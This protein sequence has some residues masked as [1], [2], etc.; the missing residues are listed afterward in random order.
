MILIGFQAFCQLD[1]RMGK[2]YKSPKRT[3]FEGYIGVDSTGAY[4]LDYEYVSK[5]KHM[6]YLNKFDKKTMN[7][8]YTKDISP[9]TEGDDYVEPVEIFNLSNK[10]YLSA[11]YIKPDKDLKRIAI[12][13]ITADGVLEKPILLDTVFSL[14]EKVNDFRI[15]VS[16][17]ENNIVLITRRPFFRNENTSF[18]V[19]KYDSNFKLI[20]EGVIT[21]PYEAKH[22]EFKDLA[23]DG[24]SKIMVLAKPMDITGMISNQLKKIENNKYHLWVYNHE[25]TS[26]KEFEISLKEK[27][28]TEIKIMYRNHRIFVSGYFSNK[29]GIALK[30]FFSIRF[31]EELN[32]LGATVK[33][34]SQ[35][36]LKKF[37][38]PDEVDERTHLLDFFLREAFV[39]ENGEIVMIGEKYYKEIDQYYDPRTDISSYTDLY[40]YN[41][42]LVT[43]ISA[44]G[45]KITNIK[46]PKY[47]QTIN[48]NGYFSSISYGIDKNVVWVFFNDNEKNSELGNDISADYRMLR[49]NRRV[50]PMYV[51]IDEQ[52]NV[53][54]KPIQLL[55]DGFVMVPRYSDQLEDGAFYFIR[56][57][58]RSAKAVR[59]DPF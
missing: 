26:I 32:V 41:S 54:R 29:R 51:R 45:E 30:G 24:Q 50:V 20:W 6:L 4:S 10:T 17:K 5:R 39:L 57:R 16:E 53:E 48:D 15:V 56:E 43:K 12:Y 38:K 58:G 49:N 27:W 36:D 25:N 2:E 14:Q 44:D 3:A 55:E 23:Y 40:N 13:P 18:N 7:L 52:N 46:I 11:R 8:T 31:D 35:D 9:I 42:V 47:Q 21:L 59:F 22:F 37:I 1:I 34:M 33:S 19:R 28:I